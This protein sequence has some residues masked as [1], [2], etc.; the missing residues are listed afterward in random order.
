MNNKADWNE[1]ETADLLGRM[2]GLTVALCT[3]LDAQYKL[4]VEGLEKLIERVIEGGGF[5][6]VSAGLVRR[7]A[8]VDSG[9]S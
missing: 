5:M 1:T 3:P 2:Q 6:P 4:D 8:A 9:C 7:A